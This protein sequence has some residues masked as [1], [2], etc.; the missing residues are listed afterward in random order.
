MEAHRHT[1]SG[2]VG[3]KPFLGRGLAEDEEAVALRSAIPQVRC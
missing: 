3:V 2:F 1:A